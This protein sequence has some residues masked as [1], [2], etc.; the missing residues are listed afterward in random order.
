MTIQQA[1]RRATEQLRDIS[2]APDVDAQRLLLHATAQNES[3]W[4]IA[5]ADQDLTPPQEEK[6]LSLLQERLTGKP[7]AYILQTSEFYG[8]PFT[9]SQAVLIPRADTEELVRQALQAI[10]A[11]A[12]REKRNLIIADIGTGSGCIAIT[13]AL[14][15]P[16]IQRIYAIDISQDALA[17]AK[18]NAQAHNVSE[19]IFFIQGNVLE[20]LQNIPLDLIVSNPPYVP[21][22]ELEQAPT[23]NTAG[24]RFEP[25]IALDGGPDGQQYINALKNSGLPAIIEVT[26]GGIQTFHLN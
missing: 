14:E 26:G 21:S 15:S 6:F 3:S 18:A 16:H 17:V 20:P 11:L 10:A 2:D 12:A 1:L 8:R 5:H 23:K 19:K 22:S 25:Q 7:L 24:L 9:V 13:L 4:L